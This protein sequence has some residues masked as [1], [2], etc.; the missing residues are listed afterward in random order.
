MR[1]STY[2]IK[3]KLV[4]H[5]ITFPVYLNDQG[6]FDFWL[7]TGGPGLIIKGSL[8]N[9]LKLKIVDTRKKGVGAGGEVPVLV[10]TVKSLQFAG[11]KLEN[12]QAIVLDIKGMDEKFE[13]KFYGCLGYDVL[14]RFKVCIDYVNQELTLI[15][16]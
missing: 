16:R 7:D 14:K 3:F 2:S 8:A 12:V 11:I 4:K 1:P 10:T 15:E 6:P 9:K 5:L 13:F